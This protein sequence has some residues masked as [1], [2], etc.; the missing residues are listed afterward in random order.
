MINVT[1]ADFRKMV[2]A[3][4]LKLAEVAVRTDLP[5]SPLLLAYFR[6]GPKGYQLVRVTESA[7][8]PEDGGSGGEPFGAS[9][10]VTDVL[11]TGPNHMGLSDRQTFARQVLDAGAVREE[12]DRH[13][14]NSS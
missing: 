14:E 9:R 3:G 2:D 8:G 10:D 5:D 1:G 6:K 4:G 7:S 13:F 12:M 11:L